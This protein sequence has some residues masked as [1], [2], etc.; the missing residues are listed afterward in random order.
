MA[1][2]EDEAEKIVPD[3]LFERCVPVN[4]FLPPLDFAPE[5]FVLA[6]KR[7]AAP[8]QVDRAMFRGPHQPGAGP[9]RHARGGPLL[10]RGNEC[11]LG[12]LLSRPDVADEASQPGDEPG[13]LDPPD[14]F[15]RAMR[16]TGRCLAT[17][18]V[19]ERPSAS[20]IYGKNSLTPP[21][22]QRPGGPR[23]SRRRRV[24]A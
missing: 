7:L 21:R 5:L 17:T 23:R 14:R 16:F 19:F 1:R 4:A 12:E 6:L 9:L 10:E 8:D 20:R 2:H 11:V 3:V 13:R 22:T 24:P 18:R 15:D